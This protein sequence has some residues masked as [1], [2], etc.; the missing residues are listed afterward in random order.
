V[1]SAFSALA[2]VRVASRIGLLN[3]A[4]FTH[5]PA[6]LFLVLT[7]FMPT[8]ELAVVF[9]LLRSALSQ[10]DVPVRNSYVMAVVSPAERPAAASVTAV[11]KSL[12]AALGPLLSGWLFSL[13]PFGWPLVIAGALKGLYDVL[14]LLMFKTIRPPEEAEPHRDATRRTQP[15]D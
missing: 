13:S 1:L 10:M 5:L 3:T 12:A 9:L 15:A 14:L 4:V 8:V 7:P 11:P 2:A 6:N